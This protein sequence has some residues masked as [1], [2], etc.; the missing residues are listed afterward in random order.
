MP[1]RSLV[2]SA[3]SEEAAVLSV[4]AASEEA[5]SVV[6]AVEPQAARL[7]ARVAASVAEI[8]FFMVVISFLLSDVLFCECVV[9]SN[10][11]FAHRAACRWNL[12]P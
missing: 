9:P 4:E 7:R 11:T 8:S 2:D 3:A 6:E 12:F 10:V 5:V 1:A